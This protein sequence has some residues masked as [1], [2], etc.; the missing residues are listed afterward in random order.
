M[1]N[2]SLGLKIHSKLGKIPTIE[3]LGVLIDISLYYD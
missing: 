3:K 2:I 1:S